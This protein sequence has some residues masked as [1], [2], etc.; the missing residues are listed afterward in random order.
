MS[1]SVAR[2]KPCPSIL[3]SRKGFTLFELLITITLLCIVVVILS[4]ALRLGI[5]AWEKGEARVADIQAP[6]RVLE[7]IGR[8]I[9]STLPHQIKKGGTTVALFNG[10]AAR[11]EFVS[12]SALS[13][14]RDAGAVHV[15]YR[16]H[17]NTETKEESLFVFEEPLWAYSST[18]KKTGDE[19]GNWREMLSG[20]ASLSF[21]YGARTE[22][23]DELSWTKEWRAD[24]QKGI[25]AAIR[26]NVETGPDRPPFSLVV[27]IPTETADEAIGR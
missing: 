13:T 23:A 2:A 11:L 21:E 10:E 4:G 26:V 15:V 8:Q 24:K 18:D 7:L 1:D 9:A 20:V 16:L 19:T 6:I 3:L 14:I 17:E 25:P 22:T 12:L 5:R 27:R